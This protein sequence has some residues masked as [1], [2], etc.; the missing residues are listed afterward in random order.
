[1]RVLGVL[2]LV[3]ILAALGCVTIDE[4]PARRALADSIAAGGK[5]E[6]RVVQTKLFKLQTYVH[7]TSSSA[8]WVVYIEGDGHVWGSAGPSVN[9]TPIDPLALRLASLDA[10]E[11][12]IY[13]A[14]P[15]QYVEG[16]CDLKYWTSHRLAVEVVDA[17][18][19][20]LR[21]LSRESG[22]HQYRLVGFSGGGGVAVL[23]AA[24]LKSESALS[25]ID[26]RTVA[27]N[28][29]HAQWTRQLG[30]MPLNGSLN[31]ANSA[32]QLADL[33]QLH[34]LGY[35][36]RVV[37]SAVY[38]SYASKVHR[39]Q[40]LEKSLQPASHVRGWSELWVEL[41]TIKPRCHA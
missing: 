32:V 6:P 5:L 40:C 7:M 21:Q 14:R 20:A 12:V 25:A 29:D 10:S 13:I 37:P 33:P 23:L 22:I 36:D 9:P 16:W 1:M 30:L 39:K 38:D 2:L 26:L 19:Q 8:P 27:G 4:L 35:D 3:A 34:F 18:E 28:L 24:R 17:Y 15:C 11:N 41:S 31:P